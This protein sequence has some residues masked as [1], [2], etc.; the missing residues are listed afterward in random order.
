MN[1]STSASGSAGSAMP[2]GVVVTYHP[3]VGFEARL[4]AI[5]REIPR[6]IVVDNTGTPE[7]RLRLEI[8]S[9]RL[10]FLPIFNPE[11]HGLAAALNQGFLALAGQGFE[12]AVAFDQDSTP[13]PGFS[14][15]LLALA[16]AEA[17]PPPAVV[18]ANWRDE[19]RPDHL[20]RHLRA[21]RKWPWLYERVP[22]RQDLEN[23]TCVIASGTLFHLPTWRALGKFDETL[24]L[25]LVDTDYCLRAHQAG[26]AIRVAAGA[27]LLHRRGSKRA[28]R[29]L[30]RT[31]W[32]AFMP[33]L[34]LRYL[35]RNRVL[36]LQRCG[37]HFP[38]WICY[39]TIYALKIFFEVLLLE[40]S[41][42]SKL[43]A[44][45]RGTWD[46]LC[47]RNGRIRTSQMSPPI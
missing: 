12:W 15:A 38:H 4:E 1:A 30:G 16:R 22:A 14:V 27:C 6:L 20:S 39:E 36:L 11:N 25:D 7:T 45:T 9:A 28:V 2:G 37:R 32:P 29:L 33:P 26:R 34:R 3:D 42:F 46:G 41:K 19:A 43:A 18:G 21:H 10:N 40:D 35:F 23:V 31:W 44:C 8:A 17:G 5:V 13:E 47:A 24:F